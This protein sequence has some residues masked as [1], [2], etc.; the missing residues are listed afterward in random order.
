MPKSLNI[1]AYQLILN[2]LWPECGNIEISRH[3]FIRANQRHI[4]IDKVYATIKGGKIK[5]LGKH[6]IKFIKKY[7]RFEVICVGQIT[8]NG[9]RIFTV[10][11]RK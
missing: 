8:C 1:N 10:E 2:S 11:T 6:R 7:K 3:A 9:V 5:C 4:G